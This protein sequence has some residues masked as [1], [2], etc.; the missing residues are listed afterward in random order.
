MRV[1]RPAHAL[2][3]AAVTPP[4]AAAAAFVPPG[5]LLGIAAAGGAVGLAQ[6][7]VLAW[8]RVPK[9]WLWAPSTA[10]GALAGELVFSR[11]AFAHPMIAL[12]FA[13]I[14]WGLAFGAFQGHVLREAS[15]LAPAWIPIAVLARLAGSVVLVT[16]GSLAM[17]PFT[18]G[19]EAVAAWAASGAVEGLALAL[20]PRRMIQ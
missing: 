13:G 14:V 11:L 3:F 15:R 8:A 1:L 20:L 12:A 18:A 6:A 9:A 10:A 4:A 16:G 2:V 17:S 7:L 19:R 5:T